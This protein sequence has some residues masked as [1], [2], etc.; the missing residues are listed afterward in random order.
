MRII[1]R[2][3]DEALVI[4]DDV[5]I[6]ILEVHQN[7]VRLGCYSPRHEPQYW[8]QDLYCDQPAN[9]FPHRNVT[10]GVQQSG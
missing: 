4:G 9:L 1:S 8:E 7:H 5:K 6:T 2:R 3:T 10:V